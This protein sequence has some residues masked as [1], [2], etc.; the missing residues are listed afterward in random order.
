MATTEIWSQHSAARGRA[1]RNL[2][3]M[4]KVHLSDHAT[5]RVNDARG[6]AV[7]GSSKS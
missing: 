4:R 1:A 2:T 3:R 6:A 7:V 5:S